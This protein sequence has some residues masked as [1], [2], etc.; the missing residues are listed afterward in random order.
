MVCL[1]DQSIILHLLFVQRWVDACPA[2]HEDFP[3]FTVR[4]SFPICFKHVLFH[5]I[6]KFIGLSVRL[7][8]V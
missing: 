7:G 2:V 8:M 1:A 6:H 4:S 5:Y 3:Y